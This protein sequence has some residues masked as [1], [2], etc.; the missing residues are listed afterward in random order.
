V[1]RLRGG[2]QLGVGGVSSEARIQTFGFNA[3]PL[4]GFGQIF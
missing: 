1:G 3:A 4:P 2:G